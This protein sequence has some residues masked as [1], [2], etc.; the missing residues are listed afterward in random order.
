[1]EIVDNFEY[2]GI[3][4][5]D[6]RKR[7]KSFDD[8][9]ANNDILMPK[10]F[11]VYCEK[12]QM[13]YKMMCTD[14]SDPSTYVF[15]PYN[16]NLNNLRYATHLTVK[17]PIGYL[18]KGD[19]L[20]NRKLLDIVAEMLKIYVK[21]SISVQMNPPNLVRGYDDVIKKDNG[22]TITITVDPGTET[23]TD[24]SKIL[25]VFRGNVS[26]PISTINYVSGKNVY[27]VNDNSADITSDTIYRVKA[28]L[29]SK[30]STITQTVNNNYTFSP[31]YYWGVCNSKNPDNLDLTTAS[32]VIRDSSK[33]KY[34]KTHH[35][36]VSQYCYF[37]TPVLITK[38]LD[39]NGLDNSPDFSHVTKTMTFA[40]GKTMDYYLYTN[41]HP[42]TC[43]NFAYKFYVK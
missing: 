5:L 30:G 21:P 23:I 26:T 22:V 16:S 4:E 31:C 28:T 43:N 6:N 15:T 27:E 7:W 1:M 29:P 2:S 17:S 42:V 9:I 24:G 39:Q 12:E 41:A 38:V 10:G 13:K 32:K 35:T 20:Y 19:D 8:L 37:F 3:K 25:E 18:N 34:I 40:N 36:G 14:E 33:D 11:E